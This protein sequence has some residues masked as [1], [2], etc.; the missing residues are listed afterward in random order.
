MASRQD[1][2]R[3]PAAAALLH[4]HCQVAPEL[5]PLLVSYWDEFH[6]RDLLSLP[7]FQYARRGE[8]IAPD[9]VAPFVTM[10]G[11]ASPAAADQPRPPEFRLMPGE[12]DGRA[13]FH[14]RIMRRI[15]PVSGATEPAGS[16]FLQLHRPL[17]GGPSSDA[18]TKVKQWP[19]VIS[20]SCWESVANDPHTQ[21][22][23]VVHLGAT[24]LILAELV[25]EREALTLLANC[26][27]QLPG[28]EASTYRQAFFAL[29]QPV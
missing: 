29:A 3:A 25:D 27:E 23:E 13:T 7:G 19:A 26:A 4:L 10:Y 5:R 28:W 20:V 6:L 8:L 16:A 15:S 2:S 11:V 17:P 22:P 18:A 12:L 24:E 14:R 1:R 9:D 21:R